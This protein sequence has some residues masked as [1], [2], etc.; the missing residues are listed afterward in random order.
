MPGPTHTYATLEVSK[1]TYRE[2]R[3]KLKKFGYADQ[4]H[5]DEG[6]ELIDMHGIALH[7]SPKTRVTRHKATDGEKI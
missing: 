1:S 6:G 4:F 5:Y 2:I 7:I 3:G